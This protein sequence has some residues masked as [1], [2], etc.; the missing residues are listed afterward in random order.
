[1]S[2]TIISPKEFLELVPNSEIVS[3]ETRQKHLKTG[4]SDMCVLG[5]MN[6]VNA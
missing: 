2:T 5:L 1:M 3:Q 4:S 6:R